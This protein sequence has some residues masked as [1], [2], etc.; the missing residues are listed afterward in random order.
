MCIINGLGQRECSARL[1]AHHTPACN[2]LSCM[3]QLPSLCEGT[4]HPRTA[5]FASSLVTRT[6]CV[7]RPVCLS[8]TGEARRQGEHDENDNTMWTCSEMSSVKHAIGVSVSVRM[9]SV[10]AEVLVPPRWRWGC[11]GVGDKWERGHVPRRIQLTRDFPEARPAQFSGTWGFPDGPHGSCKSAAFGSRWTTW[12]E[13]VCSSPG[14]AGGSL[15]RYPL[16][17]SLRPR[18]LQR[19]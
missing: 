19:S 6:V 11:P 12:P 10:I 3:H 8:Y 4:A 14:A 13:G 17:C 5:P 1:R 9:R 2:T 15:W 18:R 7:C 16:P